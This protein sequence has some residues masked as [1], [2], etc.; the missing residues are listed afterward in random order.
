MSF[1]FLKIAGK[2]EMRLNSKFATTT[3][4]I[5]VRK[6]INIGKILADRINTG[7]SPKTTVRLK[8]IRLVAE[9]CI[10]VSARSWSKV[11]S[12]YRGIQ[13]IR[14]PPQNRV[15]WSRP[16]AKRTQKTRDKRRERARKREE[17]RNRQRKRRGVAR[18][19]EE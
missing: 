10:S 18:Q 4:G 8:C 11:F 14:F 7:G 13:P 9:S 1:L 16:N 17:V 5:S 19:G 15:V 6:T 3:T 2:N 12:N